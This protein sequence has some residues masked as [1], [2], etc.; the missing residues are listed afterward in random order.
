MNILCCLNDKYYYPMLTM[1]TSIRR[2]NNETIDLYIITSD[3][4]TRYEKKLLNFC[5]SKNINPRIF[6]QEKTNYNIGNSHYSIDMYFRI[7]A[8][9]ILPTTIDKI[10]YL[11]ADL[12]FQD[13]I[14]TLYEIDLTNKLIGVVCDKDHNKPH[15]IE[16]KET[17]KI[18]HEYF[19]SGVILFNLKEFRNTFSLDFINNTIKNIN[20]KIIYPDQD[21]LNI[22]TKE[23]QI[24]FLDKK[25]NYQVLYKDTIKN[26]NPT[27]IHYIGWI[28]PWTHLKL[29]EHEIK[30]WEIFK[31]TKIRSY[32]IIQHIKMFFFPCKKAIRKIKKIIKTKK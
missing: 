15:L 23:D 30:Y 17:L 3:F 5:N 22:L 10:L 28:K 25:F 9:S 31:D 32:P 16:H 18:T 11:D 14:S 4:S 26:I 12:I 13:N 8:F 1:L 2:F 6:K 27:I 21:I 24:A 29:S 7:F 19:N 20:N